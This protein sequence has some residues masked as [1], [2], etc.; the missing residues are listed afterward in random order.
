MWHMLLHQDMPWCG[1]DTP[2]LNVCVQIL[3]NCDLDSMSAGLELCILACNVRPPWPNGQGVGLLIRRLRV[4]V[5]QGVIL[6]GCQLPNL[7]EV[8]FVDQH[9][10]AGQLYI[11]ASSE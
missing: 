3:L 5:P 9:L 11:Q 1:P 2:S 6:C 10:N 4:R 8:G 7:Y